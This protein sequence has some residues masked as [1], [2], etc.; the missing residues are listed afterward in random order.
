MKCRDHSG[1]LVAELT[2]LLKEATDEADMVSDTDAADDN[3]EPLVETI[4][5]K[6]KVTAPHRGD[7]PSRPEIVLGGRASVGRSA[8]SIA[9]G[10]GYSY[11]SQDGDRH[12]TVTLP[13]AGD[14]ALL[15]FDLP[16]GRHGASGTLVEGAVTTGM[17]MRA[18]EGAASMDELVDRWLEQLDQNLTEIAQAVEAHNQRVKQELTERL[19]RRRKLVLDEREKIASSKYPISERAQAPRPFTV[20]PITPKPVPLPT[21]ADGPSAPLTD[22][23]LQELYA[24]ILQTISSATAAMERSPGNYL[25]WEEEQLRDV[26]LLCLNMVYE[27]HARAEAFNAAG[28]TDL[29]IAV[30]GQNL[31]IGECKIW[32]GQKAIG[33][34]LEQLMGYTTWRDSRLALIL[35]VREQNIAEIAE[36][37]RKALEDRN[38]FVRW[39]DRD[40]STPLVR[41][42]WPCD[43]GR[44]AILGIVFCHLPRSA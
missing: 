38:E 37:A 36:K 7:P 35:F 21:R 8:V 23:Q 14:L 29:L 22:L 10:A 43:E 20:P 34:A 26:V 19:G 11:S 33:E 12:T 44:E 4:A 42:R 25:V 28:H 1:P 40:A 17:P 27:S 18:A 41:I 39:I 24:Q 2:R 3:L 6:H 32:H 15:C 5:A 30:D 9:I 13:L 31:F 16:S